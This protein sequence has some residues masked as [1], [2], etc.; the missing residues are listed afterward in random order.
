MNEDRV[1]EFLKAVA[2]GPQRGCGCS[3]VCR[4][5]DSG[6]LR[7]W[8]EVTMEEAYQLLR[9]LDSDIISNL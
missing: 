8:A 2:D 9:E 4:C 7:V 3:P 1:R 6:S 5:W